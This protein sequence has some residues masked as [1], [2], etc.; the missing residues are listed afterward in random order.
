MF[1]L[2]DVQYLVVVVFEDSPEHPLILQVTIHSRGAHSG[3]W[4]ENSHAHKYSRLMG[5]E[6]ALDIGSL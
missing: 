3:A 1:Y 6:G 4:M 5:S 2:V